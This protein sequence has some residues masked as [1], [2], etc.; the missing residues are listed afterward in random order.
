MSLKAALQFTL[1]AMK[2]NSNNKPQTSP[3]SCPPVEVGQIN[4]L[5]DYA[6]PCYFHPSNLFLYVFTSHSAA[7]SPILEMEARQGKLFSHPPPQAPRGGYLFFIHV[8]FFP[9]PLA[10]QYCLF[11]NHFTGKAKAKLKHGPLPPSVLS[12]QPFNAKFR[13]VPRGWRGS[14]ESITYC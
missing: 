8:L 12:S 14:G 10:V 11:G 6:V 1:P 3:L 5:G 9:G 4:P 13:I 7:E 2:A